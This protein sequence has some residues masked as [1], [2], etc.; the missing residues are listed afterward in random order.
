[1]LR[2]RFYTREP[3]G[4]KFSLQNLRANSESVFHYF[5]KEV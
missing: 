3:Y 1:M 2:L 5:V 4:E